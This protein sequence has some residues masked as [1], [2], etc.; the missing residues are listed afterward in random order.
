MLV[1][2]SFNT[3]ANTATLTLKHERSASGS[4]QSAGD[5]TANSTSGQ[6]THLFTVTTNDP[7]ADVSFHIEG[8]QVANDNSDTLDASVD[9]SKKNQD[10]VTSNAEGDGSGQAT[11]SVDYTIDVDS[12][13]VSDDAGTYTGTIIGTLSFDVPA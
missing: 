12:R 6:G 2:A 9:D 7:G 11:V 4:I 8:G 13:T 5:S 1:I 10:N 3:Y